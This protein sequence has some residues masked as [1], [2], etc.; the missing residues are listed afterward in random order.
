MPISVGALGSP[1]F[2]SISPGLKGGHGSLS[3]SSHQRLKSD[4]AVV[5]WDLW[6]VFLSLALLCHEG[7]RQETAL[8]REKSACKNTM[9]Q[10]RKE[11]VQYV[12]NGTDLHLQ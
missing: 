9:L 5:Y 7:F 11:R 10:N 12:D 8:Q 3:S 1:L 2:I 4:V 6:T